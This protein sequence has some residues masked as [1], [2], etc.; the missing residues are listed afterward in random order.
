MF[1]VKILGWEWVVFYPD[2][3]EYDWGQGKP[4]H[5]V[6]DWD[7]CPLPGIGRP[8]LLGGCFWWWPMFTLLLI[9]LG[10]AILL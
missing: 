3:N 8:P 6:E 7:N 2:E 10:A 1:A 5:S 9:G 4:W